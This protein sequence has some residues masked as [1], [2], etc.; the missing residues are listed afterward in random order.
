ML[1]TA[2][3]WSVCVDIGREHSA[4]VAATM[5]TSGQIAAMTV[6]P[7]AGYSVELLGS[8]NA[9]FWLLTALFVMGAVCWAF[10]EPEKPI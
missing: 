2:P 1:T 5:N 10:V 6:A 4:T 8:W 9:P 3:A 7:V